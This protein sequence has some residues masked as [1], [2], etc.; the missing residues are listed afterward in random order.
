MQSHPLRMHDIVSLGVASQYCCSD[1]YLY[2]CNR[3]LSNGCQNLWIQALRK[4]EWRIKGYSVLN[5]Y[6][7]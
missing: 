5:N 4:T 1:I 7:K 6:I 3:A 2:I